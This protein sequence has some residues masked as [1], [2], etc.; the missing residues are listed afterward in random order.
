MID[1]DKF[2]TFLIQR[3]YAERT[4]KH[5]SNKLCQYGDWCNMNQIG[6]QRATLEQ[7][8]AYKRSLTEKGLKVGTVRELL[9]IL[10][11][12]FFSIGRKE[13][14]ALL[15]KHQ[16]RA[17]TLPDN[18]LSETELTEMYRLCQ[19]KT[20]IQKRDREILGMI[21]FQGLRREE[22]TSL[23]LHFLDLEKATIY[24]PATLQGNARTL[25][26]KPLQLMGL[27]NYVY[28]LRPKLLIEAK[29]ETNYLFFSQS[30]TCPNRQGRGDN[31]SLSNFYMAK[32]KALKTQFPYFKTPTQLRESR[33]S[34]WVGEH[35]L[36]KAQYM[37]GIK[38][39]SSMLR[40]KRADVDRLGQKLGIVHPMEKY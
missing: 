13:N 14:P 21:I 25:N 18:L 26:L 31:N 10:K 11:H 36:R 34:L 2:R 24:I 22:L 4:V 35:G 19:A 39:T 37:A 32:C 28:E 3:G 30:Q 6:P 12:Y 40:Y 20:F 23:E 27:M 5:Y 29:K 15:I 33:L 8:Y 7:L 9:S 38:Y 1:Y 17:R 16:K